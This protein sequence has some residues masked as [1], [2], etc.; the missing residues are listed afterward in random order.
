MKLGWVGRTRSLEISVGQVGWRSHHGQ[1][2]LKHYLDWAAPTSPTFQPQ[3]LMQESCSLLGSP[4]P[5]GGATEPT[6]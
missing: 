6:A 4:F 5:Q 1:L 3:V 2:H